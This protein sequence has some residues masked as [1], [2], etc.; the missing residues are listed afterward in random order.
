MKH[1]P[2]SHELVEVADAVDMVEAGDT[3]VVIDETIAVTHPVGEIGK[4]KSYSLIDIAFYLVYTTFI[5]ADG[6]HTSAYI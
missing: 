3:G 5:K 1:G 4:H 6:K 2:W